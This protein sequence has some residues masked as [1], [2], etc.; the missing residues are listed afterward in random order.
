MFCRLFCC[1]ARNLLR[2][3]FQAQ[4]TESK[5]QIWFIKSAGESSNGPQVG[6]R[7]FRRLPFSGSAQAEP[8]ER[9]GRMHRGQVLFLSNEY[10]YLHGLCFCQTGCSQPVKITFPVQKNAQ[11]S[12]RQSGLN[13]LALK[14]TRQAPKTFGTICFVCTHALE[15]KFSFSCISPEKMFLKD[16]LL[17]IA[18]G[19]LTS[20]PICSPS[21]F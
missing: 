20:P 14:L 12:Y 2:S 13:S 8:L 9:D 6:G 21:P 10:G 3:H 4:F 18:S 7:V 11:P 1:S 16:I 17:I 15:K 5:F 19:L